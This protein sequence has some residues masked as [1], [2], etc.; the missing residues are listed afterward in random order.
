MILHEPMLRGT[1][2]RRIL[3][4][5]TSTTIKMV[6]NMLNSYTNEDLNLTKYVSVIYFVSSSQV[7]TIYITIN[8]KNVVCI[9]GLGL[10][11]SELNCHL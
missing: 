6:I 10:W 11:S 8:Q 3:K 9:G 1:F 2:Y 4:Y 5:V 7:F